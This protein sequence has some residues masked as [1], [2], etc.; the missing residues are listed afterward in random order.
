[1][2]E[3][4]RGTW[5]SMQ[6]NRQPKNVVGK[7]RPSWALSPTLCRTITDDMAVVVLFHLHKS[8][9][10]E[11]QWHVHQRLGLPTQWIGGDW[12]E[13]ALVDMM[14]FCNFVIIWWMKCSASECSLTG[15]CCCFR[16]AL[17]QSLFRFGRILNLQMTTA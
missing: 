16:S 14:V 17:C 6:T 2:F 10:C 11:Q 7:H 9:Q 12:N 1:V 5:A 8:C 13:M 3:W 4:H 15:C